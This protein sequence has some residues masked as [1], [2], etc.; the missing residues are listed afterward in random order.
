LYDKIY[1]RE[2]VGCFKIVGVHDCYLVDLKNDKIPGLI[3]VDEKIVNDDLA[4]MAASRKLSMH[5]FSN[6]SNN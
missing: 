4:F 5:Y 1:N 3:N 2:K 6:Y